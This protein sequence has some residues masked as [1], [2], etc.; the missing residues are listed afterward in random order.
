MIDILKD[1]INELQKLLELKN[2]RIAELETLLAAPRQIVTMPN[3]QYPVE[4]LCQ[5]PRFIM[6]SGT[7]DSKEAK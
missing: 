7:A 3:Y 1:Q 5:N 6:T 2:K 4:T